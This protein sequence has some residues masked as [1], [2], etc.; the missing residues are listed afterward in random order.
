MPLSVEISPFDEAGKGP[1]T[2][3]K[4][5]GRFDTLTAP[6]GEKELQPVVAGSAKYVIFDLA[7]LTFISSAGLRVLLGTRKALAARGAQLHLINLQ[8]Q[9]AK[10]LDIVKALP[11][12]NIFKSLAEMDEYLAAMQRKVEEGES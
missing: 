6:Q 10:V 1:A 9:I 3:V 5:V 4:L 11:G 2:L 7:G 12:I 8:P